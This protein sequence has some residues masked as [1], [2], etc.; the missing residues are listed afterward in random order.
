MENKDFITEQLK[1]L[2]N[3][4][5]DIL[6]MCWRR[7]MNYN[8]YVICTHNFY[9]DRYHSLRFVIHFVYKNI[10]RIKNVVV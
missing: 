6:Y 1:R 2:I 7:C 10:D 5:Y 9:G 4:Y 8:K 3:T